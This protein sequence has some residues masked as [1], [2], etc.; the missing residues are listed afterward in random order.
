MA[1]VG[2]VGALLV[3]VVASGGPVDETASRQS[4][5]EVAASLESLRMVDE[6]PLYE[7]TYVGDYDVMFN[8]DE[9]TVSSSFG[10]SLFAALGDPDQ[11][12]FARNFDWDPDAA[13]VL[14]TDPPDGFASVAIVDVRFLGL[15]PGSDLMTAEGSDLLLNGPLPVI[16]GMNEHGVA[17]GLAADDAG[18]FVPDPEQATVSGLRIM[19]LVLDGATNVAEAL[20]IIAS[21]N[22][23]F[24]GGPPLHYLVADAAGASAVVEFVDGEMVVIDGS[25]PWQALTNFQQTGATDDVFAGDWR[26]STAAAALD[27]VAGDVEPADALELL[28]SVAQ[29]HTQW[30]V[31][32]DLS[33][34]AMLVVM[35]QRWDEVHEFRV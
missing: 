19:R 12:V 11:A 28:E 13:M 24:T 32:Y 18:S 6:H 23:D 17:I 35:G 9:P 26:W 10:C 3:P 25:P 22:L 2:V 20:E 14:H 21:Y 15:E 27:A 33:A 5:D 29:G 1:V 7:M 31:A 4:A 34:R 16:D 8:V 30:S